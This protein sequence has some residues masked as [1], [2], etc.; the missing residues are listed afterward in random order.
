MFMSTGPDSNVKTRLPTH[1]HSYNQMKTFLF[2]G[3]QSD[4]MHIY[5]NNQFYLLRYL[6]VKS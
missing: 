5:N 4:K 1:Y 2:K 6:I 3:A